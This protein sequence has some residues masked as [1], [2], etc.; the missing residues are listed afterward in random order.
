MS[1][2]T[3]P[4]HAQLNAPAHGF[5]AQLWWMPRPPP[6]LSTQT[7]LMSQ[8]APSPQATHGCPQAG[9]VTFHAPPEHVAVPPQHTGTL[10]FMPG[11]EHGSPSFGARVGHCHA[12]WHAQT[13]PGPGQ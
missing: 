3:E 4:A 1:P 5:A 6:P 8:P 11:V 2:Q 13:E 12:G 7:A 10:H 9:D